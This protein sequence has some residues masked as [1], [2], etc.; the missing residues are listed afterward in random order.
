MDD[1]LL[2][3]KRNGT[4]CRNGR[5]E[6]LRQCGIAVVAPPDY[7]VMDVANDGRF[8]SVAIFRDYE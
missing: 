4:A 2:L 5:R 6:A 3:R 1:A 8:P 7:R